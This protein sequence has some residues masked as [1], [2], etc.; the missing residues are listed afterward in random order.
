MKIRALLSALFW[1]LFAIPA[2]AFPPAPYYRI[3]GTVRDQQGGPLGAGEGTIVLSGIYSALNLASVSSGGI[4]GVTINN[5]GSYTSV[6]EVTFVGANGSGRG[7]TGTAVL[8]DGV[9]T[10]VINITP[11][12][13]YLSPVAVGF[14][15]GGGTPDRIGALYH[16][17]IRRNEL[18]TLSANGFPNDLTIR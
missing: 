2:Y 15:G 5:G 7:A 16:L 18:L 6:P 4:T 3:F 14:S 9:V 12:S 8:S 13:G 11:G 10:D 1:C 17:S